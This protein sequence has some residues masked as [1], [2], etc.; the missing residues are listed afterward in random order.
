M[1]IETL[2][3][4]CLSLPHATEGIQ[5][6]NDLLFRIGG[7]MFAVVALERTP[8]SI[9]FRCT[10]EE[11]AELIEREGIIP[12]PY[13]ARNNW[14]MLESLDVLPR[15]EL[16]RLIK[17]SY[18]MVAAKL[19]KKVQAQLGLASRSVLAKKH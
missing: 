2:R 6:G 11:F 1:D 12:A 4:Y 7:K 17:D 19:T 13:M 18:G 3:R 5:W 10:P 14:V 15:T 8:T 16:K 9:S